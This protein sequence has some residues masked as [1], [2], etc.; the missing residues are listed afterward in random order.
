MKE[1]IRIGLLLD[2][3]IQPYWMYKMFEEIRR[4]DIVEI[5]LIVINQQPVDVHRSMFKKAIEQY[6]NIFYQLYRV[7]EKRISKPAPDAFSLTNISDI[8]DAT[9]ST[10]ME[11]CPI[12]KKHSDYFKDED[13]EKIKQQDIDV[14]IRLGFRILRGKILTTAKYGIWSYHHGDNKVNRGGPAGVWESIQRWEET[15]TV[16]QIITEELDGGSILNRTWA[17]TDSLFIN[18]NLNSSYWNATSLLPRALKSLHELGPE[19]FFQQVATE[20]QHPVF[21]SNPLYT[22]P[23][24]YK[25]FKL[26]V[27]KS[28]SILKYSIWRMFY[29]EQWIL[30]Y[31]FKKG[32]D[33]ATSMFR[34]KKM[35]PSKKVFWA[36]PCVIFENNKHYIFLEELI[37]KTNKGHISVIEMNSNGQYEKPQ[38]ILDKQY[39]LS[40]PF[41]FKDGNEWYMTPESAENNTIELY[42]CTSFP[43]KWEFVM[44]LMENV[45]ACDPTIHFKDGKYWLFANMRSY[46]GASASDELYL[47]YADTLM[48]DKW[49]PHVANP[50]ISDVKR[51]R[52]AGRLF[53]HNNNLYRPSQDCSGKYGK[54][55]NINHVLV[56]NEER[57][58][59]VV[60]NKIETNWDKN[61][62]RTHSLSFSNG[63]TVIDGY[64]NRRK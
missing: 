11:V 10:V 57:Y 53:I 59:E 64:F 4:Q 36:D 49:K 35:L 16:L 44:N 63:L 42:K 37:Y 1:K 55:V 30:L 51:A 45:Y 61:I 46:A 26:I 33:I 50:I 3:Y 24:N 40:Y 43:Y 48:T 6:K 15:G 13:I 8:I 52:P 22:K 54:A 27:S 62:T 9:N 47:F 29:L 18:R 2:S 56:M 58:E 39:H 23:R 34:Y 32:N 38:I 41:V 60:V 7:I 12:Q 14:F 25:F 17:C 5:K 20:N 21:Y 19:K 31:S 28:F